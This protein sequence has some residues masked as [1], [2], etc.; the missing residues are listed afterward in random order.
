MIRLYRYWLWGGLAGLALYGV[1]SGLV[2]AEALPQLPP[3]VG[4]YLLT[5]MLAIV[6]IGV[7]GCVVVAVE[8]ARSEAVPPVTDALMHGYQLRAEHCARYCHS[9]RD[10]K[11]LPFPAQ[12]TERTLQPAHRSMWVDPNADI[13]TAVLPRIQLPHPIQRR[14]P[15]PHRPC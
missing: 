8:R 5:A 6:V 4:S 9:P 15:S 12:R 11:V 13:T 14:R 1:H 2:V 7:G 10:A 3:G